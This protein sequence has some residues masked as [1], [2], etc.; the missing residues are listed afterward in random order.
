MNIAGLQKTS[1]ID[2]PGNICATVFLPGCNMRCPFCHNPGL[3]EYAGEACIGIAEFLD[4][5]ERRVKVLDGVCITGG[6]PTLQCDLMAL[7]R[8]IKTLGL[9]VKLDT[10]GT[11]SAMLQELI[12]LGYVDYVAMDIKGARDKYLDIVRTSI[13]MEDIDKS[14]EVLKNSSIDYE[15]R[16]T[17][18]PGLVM[19]EDL[20]DIAK[21]LSGARLYV[22]QQF[23]PTKSLLDPSLQETEPYSSMQIQTGTSLVR[24]Y[25]QEV[26]VRG[27]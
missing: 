21:W 27:I 4:F 22:L 7:V 2:Y 20:I 14:V 8:Q 19:L 9:K 13:D 1:L 25:V 10:N 23:R 12:N 24:P 5:L 6:E 17:V 18:V 11:N 3:V 26:M 15:F 16:T